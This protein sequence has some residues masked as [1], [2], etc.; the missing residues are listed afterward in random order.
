MG[1]RVMGRDGDGYLWMDVI[2]VGGGGGIWLCYFNQ[3]TE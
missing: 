3:L 1:L 2:T